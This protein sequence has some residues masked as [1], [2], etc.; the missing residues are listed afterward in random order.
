MTRGTDGKWVFE[1]PSARRCGAWEGG[2]SC[3]PPRRRPGKLDVPR[4][5]LVRASRDSLH[6][7]LQPDARVAGTR[8]AVLGPALAR[9]SQDCPVRGRENAAH[10][11]REDTDLIRRRIKSVARVCVGAALLLGAC[12][13]QEPRGEAL[14]TTVTFGE[15]G[16]SPG[17]FAYPRC[18]DHDGRSLWIID[19]LARVQRIDPATGKCEQ[20][21]KMPKWDMGKPCGVTAW[22]AADDANGPVLVFVADTHE[23]RVMVYEA[24]AR[25][26]EFSDTAPPPPL[27]ASFGSYGRGDGQFIYPTDIGVLPTRDE[28]SIERLY[29]TEYGGN[30]RVSIWEPRPAG[31]IG[32]G[33]E[34]VFMRSFGRFGSSGSAEQ[35][36]F[37][38]PQS[39]AVSGTRELVI[40]D[41]CNHRVG[42]F[43]LE[44][45]LVKWIG[46]IGDGPG[47]LAYPYGITLPGDGSAIVA[48]YGNNRVQRV[49]LSTGDCLGL[50]GHAGRTQGSLATPWGVA[51]GGDTVYVLDSGNSRV[52]GFDRPRGDRRVAATGATSK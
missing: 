21:W 41:A 34:F 20:Y 46:S 48:E 19:K 10:E 13:G 47:Q 49:S 36:E 24:P 40:A 42:R 52:Q 38:R 45:E 25:V 5:A 9:S 17:Q 28:M 50:F 7:W 31:R 11:P 4:V 2:A 15:S 29:V 14:V 44:G 6:P 18:I 30:D 27:L 8:H 32:P 23:H 26:E 12:D 22:R 3:A 16:A 37:N 1:H 43:T 51:L 35:V 39:I 33:T